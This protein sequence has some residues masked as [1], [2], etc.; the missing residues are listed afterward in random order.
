MNA[1]YTA[2]ISAVLSLGFTSTAWASTMPKAETKH[3]SVTLGLGPSLAVDMKLSPQLTVGGSASVP[4]YYLLD[5]HYGVIRYDV[6]VAYKFMQEGYFSLSAVAGIW[7]DSAVLLNK[8]ISVS[9]VGLEL[10]LALAFEF[11]PERLIGR[12]NIVP[13]IAF[14]PSQGGRGYFPPGGG[15][16]LAYR[17]SPLFEVTIGANG[18]GDLLGAHLMF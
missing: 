6:R 1:L 5:S 14:T 3:S 16:E 13:G 15:I 8:P 17:L 18:N 2:M 9:P 4:I 12:L 10:G 11:V 7:G